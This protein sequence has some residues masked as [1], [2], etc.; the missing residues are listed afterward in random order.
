MK[1]PAKTNATRL[2]DSLGIPYEL[3]AYD[4]DLNDLSA[5]NV[6]RKIDMPA[7]QVFKTL[8]VEASA[9]Q[10]FFAVIPGDQELDLKKMA[11]A[12]GKARLSKANVRR[13]QSGASLCHRNGRNR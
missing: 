7:E 6:A 10:H 13:C 9:S 1:A 12:A 4:V 2:L 3:R 8:V 11:F 5:I